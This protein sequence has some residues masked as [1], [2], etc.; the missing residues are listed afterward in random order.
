M[1]LTIPATASDL[2]QSALHLL[3]AVVVRFLVNCL[4]VV[5]LI[6]QP[7]LCFKNCSVW[8]VCDAAV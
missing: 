8:V 2:S 1:F 5:N 3:V 7:F 4:A 6:D